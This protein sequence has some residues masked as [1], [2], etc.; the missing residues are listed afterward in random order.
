MNT[1]T[2]FHPDTYSYHGVVVVDT[3]GTGHAQDC[4]HAATAIAEQGPDAVVLFTAGGFDLFCDNGCLDHIVPTDKREGFEDDPTPR[5]TPG[6]KPTAARGPEMT[7]DEIEAHLL[8]LGRKLTNDDMSYS[9]SLAPYAKRYLDNYTGTFEFLVDLKTRRSLSTGQA[10]GVLNCVRAELI[11][12]AKTP[13]RT[14]AETGLD[15]SQLPAGRYGVPGHDTRLKVLVQHGKEGSKW[16]G[17]TFVKDAAE[18]GAGTRYGMQKPDGPYI[19]D[20]E[21]ELAA[22]LADPAAAMAKYGHLTSTCGNCGRK[23]EDE[24]SVER[25]IGPYC[26]AKLGY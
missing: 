3:N 5:F 19:G 20:I 8:A 13:A 10:R 26:A 16:E 11:R 7:D 22:I 9:P 4:E 21:D 2:I 24:E 23:L 15:L 18:Y 1:D 6:P 25:G 17:F 12:N 14:K